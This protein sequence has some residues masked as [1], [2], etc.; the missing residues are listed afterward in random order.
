MDYVIILDMENN[1]LYIKKIKGMT[2]FDL[3]FKMRRVFNTKSIGHTGTLDPNATGVMVLLI[4]KACKANQFLVHDTKEY[5]ATVKLGYETDTLDIDGNVIKEMEYQSPSQ[6]A[7]LDVFKTFI[8]KQIQIPPMTSAIKVNGKKLVDYQ[9]EGKEVEI[10]AREVE[11]FSLDLLSVSDDGF[12]FKTKVSSGTY[13]RT[14]MKDILSKMGLIGTLVELERTKVGDV[15]IE[16]CDS[17]EEVLNGNYHLHSLYDALSS[18]YKVVEYQNDKDIRNGK[19][20]RL[21]VEED[22]VLMVK[23]NEVLAIYERVNNNEFKCVRGLF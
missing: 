14:L 7:Y 21:N 19:R 22:R 9:R 18:M 6:E 2:S 13:I 4:D 11:I 17:Y 23:D 3:C 20:I 5:I 8:G 16:E 12:V 15:S 10:P 1:V